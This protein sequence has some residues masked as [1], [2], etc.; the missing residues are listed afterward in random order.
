VCSLGR[1]CYCLGD[2]AAS[3]SEPWLMNFPRHLVSLT[4]FAW[5]KG[6][7]DLV[8]CEVPVRKNTAFSVK[9]FINILFFLMVPFN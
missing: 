8:C 7:I 1:S 3:R 6:K 5:E 9:S 4:Y 2:V